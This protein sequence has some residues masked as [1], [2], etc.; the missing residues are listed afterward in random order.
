MEWLL[1]ICAY[2]C[3]VLTQVDLQ[4]VYVSQLYKSHIDCSNVW[5]QADRSSL[6]L[7]L[8]HCRFKMFESVCIYMYV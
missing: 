5:I 1:I 7:K 8:E 2:E 3:P 6:V 4:Y